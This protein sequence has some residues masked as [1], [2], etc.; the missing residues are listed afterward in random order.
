MGAASWQ[1]N[2]ALLLI[3]KQS[4]IQ[5]LLF[6]CFNLHQPVI[7]TF[8][9][10]LNPITILISM[11]YISIVPLQRFVLFSQHWAITL[12]LHGY[13]NHKFGDSGLSLG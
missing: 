5:A 2:R 13:P 3:I 12:E 6:S 1:E 11:R 4:D 10:S 7:F 9:S 8:H